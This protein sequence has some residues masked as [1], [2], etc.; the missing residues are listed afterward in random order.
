MPSQGIHTFSIRLLGEILGRARSLIGGKSEGVLMLFAVR[1]RLEGYKTVTGF[2][3][4]K[5]GEK[6]YT[7]A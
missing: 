1:E 6:E 5:G 2:P 4:L 7:A 3:H